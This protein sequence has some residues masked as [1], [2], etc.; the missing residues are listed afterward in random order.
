MKK[1]VCAVL[2]VM[3][4]GIGSGLLAQ[5]APDVIA[6][7]DQ[8]EAFFKTAKVTSQKQLTGDQAVTSPWILM[9]EENG[10]RHQALWKDIFGERIKGFK[11][12]W[13]GEAV[14]KFVADLVHSAKNHA[15]IEVL[16]N[17]QITGASGFVGNF[18]TTVESNG[19]Q[20]ELQ[21]GVVILAT[22]AHSL[23]PEEYLYG[24]SDR[25]TRWHELQKLLDD[26]PQR[27]K[28]AEAVAFIQ[29]VGSREVAHDYC[30][31]IC[32][33]YATKEAM[34][35]KEHQPELEC[36]IFY[37]DVRAFG[38]G[39]E[40]YWQRAKDAGVKYVR[41]RPA[42]VA[43][44]PGTRNLQ[45]SYHED[46]GA[47]ATREFDL[48]VLSNGM[49]P[50]RSAKGLA[51]VLGLEL[52]R[53]GFARTGGFH[54][55][56]TSRPG[57]YACGPFAGPKDIPETVVE[58]SA[59][60]CK[61]MNLLAGARHTLTTKREYPPEKDVSGQEPRIGVF[62]CHCGSNI[63]GVIDVEALTNWA[64]GLPHVALARHYKYM[65]SDPGQALVRRDIL[66]ANLN[67]I[68][69]A[70]CSPH[71]HEETFRTAVAKGGLNAFYMQMVN[72]REHDSWVHTDKKHATRKAIDE[73]R[74]K[75][76]SHNR[77]RVSGF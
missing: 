69:V 46:G 9:L 76:K 58:A 47:L 64:G 3:V 55:V 71:L 27:L 63:A 35:A 77:F 60:A 56:D 57:V 16:T 39:F 6:K 5:L 38:K 2:A 26:E 43:E 52:D 19:T 65:C 42:A 61:A 12:T 67:R 70:S 45:V 31:S 13:K 75:S 44:V 34:I 74:R 17:T 20:R 36:S 18:A 37:I 8:W 25:V 29:C 7:Y 59:A 33:M 21:H 48:V 10:V 66:E 51:G 28:E 72:I 68:V 53:H 14:G 1:A 50:A 41:C 30:S 15:N 40:A 54:P 24:Q 4:L 23:T 73:P 22:G 49:V 11:E 62:V 32:C